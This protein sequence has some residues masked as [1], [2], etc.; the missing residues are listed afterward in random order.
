M[1]KF[2][3]KGFHILRL[4][5]FFDGYQKQET[6]DVLIQNEK[7]EKGLSAAI[8]RVESDANPLL[9]GPEKRTYL[10]TLL[11]NGAH[12]WSLAYGFIELVGYGL[13]TNLL[14]GVDGPIYHE[15]LIQNPQYAEN[16]A[17]GFR[18]LNNARFIRGP[19]GQN[20][21]SLLIQNAKHLGAFSHRGI[22]VLQQ[23]GLL[24]GAQGQARLEFLI[25]NPQLGK[26]LEFLHHCFP[27]LDRGRNYLNVLFKNP[28]YAAELGEG[29]YIMDVAGLLEDAQ[30]FVNRDR[31]I[32][33]PK[34]AKNIVEVLR[35]LLLTDLLRGPQGQVNFN[36]LILNGSNGFNLKPLLNLTSDRAGQQSMF[37]DLMSTIEKK[38]VERGLRGAKILLCSDSGAKKLSMDLIQNIMSYMVPP[39]LLNQKELYNRIDEIG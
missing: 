7:P 2:F 6:F 37:D 10:N 13:F 11:Q 16:L 8:A 12:A 26:G 38:A 5:G 9:R 19:Q 39:H 15:A 30:G 23:Y 35:I 14:A 36:R 22:F 1:G 33:F 29:I 25:Q 27:E 18:A 28:K 4:A 24:T 31:F 21:R 32:R 20:N 34:Y 3:I 17:K